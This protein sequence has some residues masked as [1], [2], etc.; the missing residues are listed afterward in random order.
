M[1][2]ADAGGSAKKKTISLFGR[3]STRQL[4]QARGVFR[5]SEDPGR[6]A[7]PRARQVLTLGYNG[8]YLRLGKCVFEDKKVHIAGHKSVC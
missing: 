2:G 5:R 4:W 1:C 3:K 6:V 8:A 7:S